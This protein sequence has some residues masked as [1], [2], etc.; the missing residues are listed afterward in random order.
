VK[1]P[2]WKRISDDTKATI[3]RMLLEKIPLANR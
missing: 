2:K 1:N 3:K